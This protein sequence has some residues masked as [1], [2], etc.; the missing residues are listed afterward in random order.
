MRYD[1]VLQDRITFVTLQNLDYEMI[2]IAVYRKELFHSQESGT[3]MLESRRLC[4]APTGNH[5]LLFKYIV[6]D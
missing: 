5:Q 6:Y 2:T 4:I 1:F 3:T